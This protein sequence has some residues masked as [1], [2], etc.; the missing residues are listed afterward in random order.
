MYILPLSANK[1]VFIYLFILRKAE[2]F[3]HYYEIYSCK[4]E[5]AATAVVASIIL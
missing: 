3:C 2:T 5:E 4:E 1:K